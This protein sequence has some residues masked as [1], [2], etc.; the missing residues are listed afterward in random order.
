MDDDGLQLLVREDERRQL[1]VR[2]LALQN[3]LVPRARVHQSARRGGRGIGMIDGDGRFLEHYDWLSPL[4]GGGGGG[5][6]QVNVGCGDRPAHRVDRHAVSV[7]VRW[8]QRRLVLMLRVWDA[9]AGAM[10]VGVAVGVAMGVAVGVV[11]GG[12]GSGRGMVVV[13]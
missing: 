2:H 1:V 4:R 7:E 6:S 11:S 5:G 10:A 13:T 8:R 9:G 3:L 12:G